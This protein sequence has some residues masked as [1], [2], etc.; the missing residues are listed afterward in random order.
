M[1]GSWVVG[2]R[3]NPGEIV[4]VDDVEALLFLSLGQQESSSALLTLYHTP[5]LRDIH[6]ARRNMYGGNPMK[7]RR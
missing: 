2:H 7:W 6:C 5:K 1:H 4:A 3:R